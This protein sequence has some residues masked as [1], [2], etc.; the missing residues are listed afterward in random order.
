MRCCL[1]SVESIDN[2][3]VPALKAL[4]LTAGCEDKRRF[5]HLLCDHWQ[6]ESKNLQ[7]HLDNIID[8]TAFIRVSK[9]KYRFVLEHVRL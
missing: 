5:A 7:S 4:Y 2:Y 9:P 6:D 1:A 3:L 8:S